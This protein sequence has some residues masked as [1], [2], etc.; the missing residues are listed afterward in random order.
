MEANLNELMLLTTVS[1]REIY[2]LGL[3]KKYCSELDRALFERS[4]YQITPIN[5]DRDSKNVKIMI[6][7]RRHH[8][9]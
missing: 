8:D 3:G 9:R 2:E 6:I 1:I 4:S 7:L 5:Q